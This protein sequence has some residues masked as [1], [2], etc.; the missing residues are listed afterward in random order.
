MSKLPRKL[1]LVRLKKK[2]AAQEASQDL[3]FIDDMP[4]IFLGEIP[5]M[6]THGV[7]IGHKS[8]RVY[9]GFHIYQFVELS[10]NEV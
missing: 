10:D 9:S 2:W 8:G 3:P 1:S 5:N 4:L 6:R 7:F